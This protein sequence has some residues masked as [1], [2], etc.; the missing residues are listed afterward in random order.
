M[1]DTRNETERHF[2]EIVELSSEEMEQVQ[3]G[4]RPAIVAV[5]VEAGGSADL[6]CK[7]LDD[8]TDCYSLVTEECRG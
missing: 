3:G 2:E 8:F 4:A 1:A 7:D 5:P 6:L